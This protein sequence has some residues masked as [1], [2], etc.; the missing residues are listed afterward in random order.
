MSP[1]AS[2]FSRCFF[3][4]EVLEKGQSAAV[5]DDTVIDETWFAMSPQP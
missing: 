2:L 3:R 4:S 1:T 5:G